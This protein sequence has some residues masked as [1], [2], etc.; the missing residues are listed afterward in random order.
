MT[1]HCL[2]CAGKTL[3]IRYALRRCLGEKQPVI[4]YH[5]DKYIF[6]SETVE[7]INPTHLTHPEY[8]WC[9][10][11]STDADRLPLMIYDPLCKLFPIYVTSPREE[12]WAKLHQLRLPELIIMNPWTRTELGKA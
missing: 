1:N 11:D 10:V 6:F 5:W 7:I 8:T 2:A 4:W 9:F 3:W 12:R